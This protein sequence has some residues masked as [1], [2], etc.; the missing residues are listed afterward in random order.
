MIVAIAHQ[1]GSAAR[2]AVA[3]NLAVLRARGGRKVLLID[4]D[5]RKLACSW[6]GARSAAGLRPW[7]PARAVARDALALE[8]DSLEPNYNDIVIDTEARDT[9]DSRSALIAA[10]LVIVPV[11]ADQ[12]DLASQYKLIARLNSARMFNPGLRVLFVIVCVRAEP[13]DVELATIRAYVSRVM[14]ASLAATLIHLPA[15]LDALCGP[16][17]CACDSDA[18]DVRAA[19]E[20]SA[21]YREVFSA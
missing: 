5:P 10:R 4:T 12:V 6:S 19:H 16:G 3:N 13:S 1:T 8:L 11:Q 9:G 14:S 2:S 15:A 20:M 7:V 17:S 18:C 21:L